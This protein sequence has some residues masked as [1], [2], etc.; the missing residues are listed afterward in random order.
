MAMYSANLVS[1]DSR[2]GG[3]IS[4]SLYPSNAY[5]N[6]STLGGEI[7]VW[8]NQGSPMAVGMG[9]TVEFRVY[10]YDDYMYNGGHL[11]PVIYYYP[12]STVI[13]QGASSFI[14]LIRFSDIKIPHRWNGS[15]SIVIRCS[16]MSPEETSIEGIHLYLSGTVDKWANS[17]N[18]DTISRF[19]WLTSAPDF[20]DDENP[21]I[22]YNNPTGYSNAGIKAGIYD[23]NG[24]EAFAAYRALDNPLGNSYTFNLTDEERLKMRNASIANGG[25]LSV[26]FYLTTW[27]PGGVINY[28]T[29]ARTLRTSGEPPQLD[30]TLY[31]T[32]DGAQAAIGNPTKIIKGHNYVYYEINATPDEGATIKSYTAKCGDKTL[33]TQSGYFENVD[34]GTFTFTATDNRGKT[35]TE[36]KTLSVIEYFKPTINQEV[37]LE[38]V[39]ETGA[40][41]NMKITGTYWNSNFGLKK[42]NLK[43]SFRKKEEGGAWTGWQDIQEPPYYIE[44]YN[45]GN[46][47]R[48]E[49]AL[50]GLDYSKAYT[51]QCAVA[52]TLGSYATTPEYTAK[53]IPVFDWSETDFNFNVP[54]NINGDLNIT[55]TLNVGGED[56]GSGDAV[57]ETG[58]ASMG[59][60]GTWY[61]SKWKSGKAEC[62]GIRN[63]GNMGVSNA[64]G[65][66]YYS[67]DVFNQPLPEIFTEAPMVSINLQGN[68]T[69]SAWIAKSSAPTA[70]NSGN[71]VVCRGSAGT[72]SQVYINFNV[73]GRWK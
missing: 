31:D 20:S 62:Y 45:D 38:L 54:V 73:I 5:D 16:I 27:Q 26:L 3:T 40:S 36:T 33:T 8:H 9:W 23:I 41:A 10:T 17:F 42:N 57:I 70:T 52:D 30:I 29:M 21:T 63:F 19:A 6:Y 68:S 65:G 59:S 2:L 37:E 71:F 46:T 47:F 50:T 25:E 56:S 1:S 69:G 11:A 34:S 53:L 55:G 22:Y 4:F 48:S 72:L 60:N 43:I 61:W 66:V 49:F 13:T 58:T 35:K 44:I 12:Q 64:W 7:Q 67:V 24:V 18:C 51:F 39:G 14:R 28:S 32:D 15:Q